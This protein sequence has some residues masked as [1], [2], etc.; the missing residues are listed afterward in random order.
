M[1]QNSIKGHNSLRVGWVGGVG[2]DLCEWT[3]ELSIYLN[4]KDT[5][6]ETT[7]IEECI[8]FFIAF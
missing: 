3:E 5:G 4:L 1:M 7:P 6:G 8:S 2:S